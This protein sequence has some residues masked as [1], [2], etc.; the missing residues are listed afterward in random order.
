MSK[1]TAIIVEDH[2]D[3]RAVLKFHLLR[4]FDIHILEFSSAT[5]ALE[6]LPADF[7]G[8]IFCDLQMP[9]GGAEQLYQSLETSGKLRDCHFIL[10]TSHREMGDSFRRL[11]VPIFDKLAFGDLIKFTD[12][13]QVFSKRRSSIGGD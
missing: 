4:H 11:R 2:H 5:D 13:L 10:W 9:A 8:P 12:N 3:L 6:N 1:P 7:K